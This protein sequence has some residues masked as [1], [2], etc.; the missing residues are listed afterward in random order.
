MVWSWRFLPLQW[1]RQSLELYRP[2]VIFLARFDGACAEHSHGWMSVNCPCPAA[3]SLTPAVRTHARPDQSTTKVSFTLP[4]STFNH[5]SPII[6]IHLSHT[7]RRVHRLIILS[8][9]VRPRRDVFWSGNNGAAR[10]RVGALFGIDR[11]P[12]MCISTVLGC[13]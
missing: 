6:I 5:N 12:L 3:L 1:R 9:P 4:A 8:R 13:E 11:R 7:F 2:A 10:P